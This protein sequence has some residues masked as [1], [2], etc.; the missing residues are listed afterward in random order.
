MSAYL[1]TWN[2]NKWDWNDQQDAI[3][4]VNNGD[5][6]DIY[7]SCGVTKRIE[8]GDLFFLMRLG[9]EPKGIIGCGYVSS[10]PY[11]LPHWDEQ[12]AAEG[13]SALR[14]DLLFKALS[15]NPIVSLTYLEEKYPKR[16]W[17]PQAGGLSIPDEI[18]KELFS[19]IQDNRNYSFTPIDKKKMQLFAE[20]KVKSVTYKTYDRSP[21][22]RQ[23]CIEHYGYNCSVC[24]Y[25]FEEAFGVI[26]AHYIEVHHLNQIAHVGEEYL[27]NPK[28]DLRPVCANCHRMLHK[29]RP[30]LSIEELKT[31]NKK[32]KRTS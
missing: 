3:Y 6:Y 29:T 20:G 26:G 17:T 23:A 5:Q 8:I 27:I 4:R 32:I 9:V 21:V 16:K 2:P 19:V 12:K 31:H 18:A 13:K 25:S 10:Q 22:A 14:T 11:S 1:Y 28:T 24:G 7:W 15:E 30:P